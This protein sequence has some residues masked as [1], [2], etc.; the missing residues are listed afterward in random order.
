MS[1]N[2]CTYYTLHAGDKEKVKHEKVVCFAYL[3]TGG[4][5]EVTYVPI[6][7]DGLT[8]EEAIF[9]ISLL[10]SM[11]VKLEWK[12]EFVTENRNGVECQGVA[13]TLKTKGIERILIQLHL[14]AFRVLDEFGFIV[15]ELYSLKDSLQDTE[16]VFKEFQKIHYKY[17]NRNNMGGHGLILSSRYYGQSSKTPITIDQFHKNLENPSICSVQGYFSSHK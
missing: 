15:K 5:H 17:Y 11:F 8:K 9:Y 6:L 7:E 16:D 3:K 13:F 1:T 14:T 12:W 4:L 10:T 2:C